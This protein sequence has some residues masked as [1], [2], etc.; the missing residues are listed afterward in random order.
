MSASDE[1]EGWGDPEVARKAMQG[2]LDVLASLPEP[3]SEARRRADGWSL[4]HGRHTGRWTA[5]IQEPNG[6]IFL[7][8]F[9]DMPEDAEAAAREHIAGRAPPAAT[10]EAE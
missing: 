8:D 5:V 6:D 10:A 9:F 7:T 2:F 4:F 3:L 1:P